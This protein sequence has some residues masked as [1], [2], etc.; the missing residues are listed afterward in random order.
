M[1]GTDQGGTGHEAGKE[2]GKKFLNIRQGVM[3]AT[4]TSPP[5]SSSSS[6]MDTANGGGTPG[7]SSIEEQQPPS[8]KARKEMDDERVQRAALFMIKSQLLSVPQ[9]K[10]WGGGGGGRE[11]VMLVPSFF[12][13]I[14][15]RHFPPLFSHLSVFVSLSLLFLTHLHYF[16]YYHTD[17][18]Y[19]YY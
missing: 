11:G 15:P 18:I 9:V 12:L 7:G 5:A 1:A 6:N 19:A 13:F 8:K 16:F 17:F 2:F 10:C 3:D 4:S 14:I